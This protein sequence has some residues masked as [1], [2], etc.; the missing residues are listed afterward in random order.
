MIRVLVVDDDF[1]VAELHAQ[2]VRTVP[3]F[4]VVGTALDG[5]RARVAD[6]ELAPDLVL[7]DMYLPDGLGTDLLPQLQADVLMVTAARDAASVRA[8]L[9]GGAVN[10]LVKPFGPA[11][12]ADR[13][14]AYATYRTHL[15]GERALDQTEVDRAVRL[16][17]E[18]DRVASAVP[19]GRSVQTATLVVDALKAADGPQSAGEVAAA[20]GVSRATAQRYLADLADDG[21][22]DVALRYGATGRPEHRYGLRTR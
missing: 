7:L 12:L 4:E 6:R 8:A 17:H 15:R 18:G 3:G 13:L 10:Y 22:V 20:L 5:A 9:S 2:F 21:R 1:R 11:D 14:R 16:L 19:K